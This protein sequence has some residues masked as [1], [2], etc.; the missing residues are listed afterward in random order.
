MDV[1][2]GYIFAALI[3][4]ATGLLTLLAGRQKLRAE[5]G[6]IKAD[7]AERL[8]GI[9]MNLIAPL[10]GRIADLEKATTLQAG[11]IEE[12]SSR[13][14]SANQLIRVLLRG[15]AILMHQLQQ[16][17]VTPLF[18]VPVHNGPDI[19]VRELERRL[20]EELENDGE[21]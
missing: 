1:D 19:D 7:E 18:V 2:I 4:A 10:Q 5:T 16:L 14:E 6:K 13:L 11:A 21:V 3:G 12:L 8:T 9:A 17:D 20:I 15:V